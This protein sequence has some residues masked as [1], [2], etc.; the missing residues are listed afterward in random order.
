MAGLL[1]GL[2]ERAVVAFAFRGLLSGAAQASISPIV[3]P[4]RF[5]SPYTDAASRPFVQ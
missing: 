5:C 4:V 1:A 2:S 3:T